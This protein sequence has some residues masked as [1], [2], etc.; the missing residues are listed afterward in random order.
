MSGM[1]FGGMD[2]VMMKE[3][4]AEL[5]AE[6][7]RLKTAK[8]SRPI[9]ELMRERDEARA[10]CAAKERMLSALRCQTC[11]QP[12]TCC[13]H[14]NEDGHCEVHEAECEHAPVRELRVRLE[15]A[16]AERESMRRLAANLNAKLDDTHTH[17]CFKCDGTVTGKTAGMQAQLETMR[18]ALE[19]EAKQ[20]RYW[21]K[22][23][24]AARMEAALLPS[25]RNNHEDEM[26]VVAGE[27]V[28]A[29]KDTE[30]GT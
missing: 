20:A 19:Y 24:A 8:A 15:K 22:P 29:L 12:A 26:D 3:R 28:H 14:G 25:S 7:A 5:E 11:G 30:D 17:R 1:G 27:M 6:N 16:E 2:V 4:I 21:D 10:A 13:G 18:A 9:A 23:I